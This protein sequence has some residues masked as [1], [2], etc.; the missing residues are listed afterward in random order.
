MHQAIM[1]AHLTPFDPVYQERLASITAALAPQTGDYAAQAQAT[2]IIYNV[3]QQ[4]AQLAA[5]VDNFRLF[6][7]IC[8]LCVPLVFLFKRVQTKNVKSA[9][10]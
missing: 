6:G 8:I 1:V 7:I 2:G 10:H 5:F 3:M 4:Q 9:I